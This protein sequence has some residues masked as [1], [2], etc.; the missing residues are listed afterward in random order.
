MK[1]GRIETGTSISHHIHS[2]S[3]P[4]DIKHNFKEEILYPEPPPGQLF[5]LT[6]CADTGGIPVSFDYM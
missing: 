6:F 1:K 4:S 2:R 5:I 3:I